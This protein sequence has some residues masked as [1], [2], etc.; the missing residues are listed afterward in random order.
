MGTKS[1]KKIYYWLPVIVLFGMFCVLGVLML[2]SFQKLSKVIPDSPLADISWTSNLERA[3]TSIGV[4]VKDIQIV[5]N[6]DHH[7]QLQI[8]IRNIVNE[9]KIEPY[10]LVSGI[11]LA[12]GAGLYTSNNQPGRIDS[13][14]VIVTDQADEILYMVIIRESDLKAAFYQ[15]ISEQEYLDRWII[16][17]N[18][19]PFTINSN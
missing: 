17:E 1:K 11:Q 13:I 19:P 12:V 5:G 10:Y 9:E 8:T 4:E 16:G 6:L 7:R 3:L 2:T 14:M 15:E 18:A